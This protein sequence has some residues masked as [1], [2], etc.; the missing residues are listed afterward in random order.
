MN[1]RKM[2]VVL[3]RWTGPQ[4]GELTLAAESVEHAKALAVEHLSQFPDAEITDAYAVDDVADHP[5]T[6]SKKIIAINEAYEDK[7][8]GN[9]ISF[10]RNPEEI[11]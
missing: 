7:K 4:Q 10:P 6:L 1:N 9:V 5:I 3:A 2:Y 8:H 11:N